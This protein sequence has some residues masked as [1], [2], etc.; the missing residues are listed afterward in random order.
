[1]LPHRVIV[2]GVLLFLSKTHHFSLCCFCTRH[3]LHPCESVKYCNE[4]VSMSL[5]LYVCMFVCL[6]TSIYKNS[7][8]NLLCMLP[9]SCSLILP[10]SVAI[11]YIFPFL[12]IRV[13]HR[14]VGLPPFHFPNPGRGSDGRVP[15]R[16]R[17]GAI[18]PGKL[19]EFYI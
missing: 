15:S 4:C 8:L 17:S 1:M 9:V 3:I 2:M 16:R 12:W 18:A 11:H 6:P 10:W 5:Y 19:L 7:C 13:L 14:Y